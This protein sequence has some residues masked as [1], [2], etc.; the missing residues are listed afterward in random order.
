MTVMVLAGQW[1]AS[2]TFWS[3][4]GVGVAV[5]SILLSPLVA[6]WLQEGRRRLFYSMPTAT[7]LITRHSLLTE[8]VI[9]HRGDRLSNPHVLEVR[10]AC[11]GRH[12]IPS[13]AFDNGEPLRLDVGVPIVNILGTRTTPDAARS[14]AVA[15]DGTALLIAP[16]LIKRGQRTSF[17]LLVDGPDPA[18][19]CPQPPLIDVDVQ[20]QAESAESLTPRQTVLLVALLVLTSGTFFVSDWL[21]TLDGTVTPLVGTVSSL[22]LLP[23]SVAIAVQLAVVAFNSQRRR[24]R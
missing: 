4:V 6:R 24:S 21:S 16:S 23:V 8:L 10:L 12:D 9:V 22:I 18:L 17:T 5:V 19:T 1:Y 13:S 14:P 2:G 11:Q 15:M 20:H 3:I 7:P